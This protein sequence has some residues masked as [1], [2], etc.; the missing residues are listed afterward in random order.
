MK[1]FKFS[2]TNCGPCRMMIPIWNK[3]KEENTN[4]KIEFIDNIIDVDDD[5]LEYVKRFDVKQVPTIV[6]AT[7]DLHVLEKDIGFIT[8]SKLISIIEKYGDLSN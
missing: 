7:D 2:T 8:K 3:I 6:F 1:I 4:G 5:S